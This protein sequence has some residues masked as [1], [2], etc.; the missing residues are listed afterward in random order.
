MKF[1][2]KKF[3]KFLKK[4]PKIN[5]ASSSEPFDDHSSIDED[6]SIKNKKRSLS[7]KQDVVSPKKLK[8]NEKQSENLWVFS[9]IPKW[10]GKLIKSNFKKPVKLL[11]VYTIIFYSRFGLQAAV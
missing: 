1:E 11:N 3:K 4:K 7:N 10:G 8:V 5:L 9:N 2:S 6:K